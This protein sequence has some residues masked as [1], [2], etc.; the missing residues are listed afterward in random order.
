M[1]KSR[2]KNGSAT[3]GRFRLK[4]MG[5][6]WSTARK[7]RAAER[8]VLRITEPETAAAGKGEQGKGKQ[9]P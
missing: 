2:R 7:Q 9:K 8:V 1:A 4:K 3:R 5:K 6:G